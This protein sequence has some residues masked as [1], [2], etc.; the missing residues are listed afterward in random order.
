MPKAATQLAPSSDELLA[1]ADALEQMPNWSVTVE[2]VIEA[3]K[4]ILRQRFSGLREDDLRK[5]VDERYREYL[6]KTT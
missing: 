3:E 2:D 5:L 1:F 4:T 6:D